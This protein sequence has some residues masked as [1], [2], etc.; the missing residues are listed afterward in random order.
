[1]R[2]RAGVVRHLL[3]AGENVRQTAHVAGALHV[4]LAAQ[5]VHA[6]ARHADVAAEHGQVGERLDVVGAGGVLGD[7]H[8]IEDAAALG[9]RKEARGLRSGPG[10]GCP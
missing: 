9:P 10:R 1:M 5:R 6:G 3:V 4:V 8:A 7:P 2:S